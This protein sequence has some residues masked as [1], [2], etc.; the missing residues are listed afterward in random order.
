MGVHAGVVYV[1]LLLNFRENFTIG[2]NQTYDGYLN[3]PLIKGA[4]YKIYYGLISELN[5]VSF[6]PSVKP[7]DH[8]DNLR[9]IFDF[10]WR[11][12]L[13]DGSSHSSGY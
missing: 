7:L 3:A 6:I 5:G 9:Q 11:Q 2:D 10:E 12:S 13:I 4:K 8:L 1:K